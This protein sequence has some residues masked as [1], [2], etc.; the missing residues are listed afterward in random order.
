[1]SL[2]PLPDAADRLAEALTEAREPVVDPRGDLGVDAPR[3]LAHATDMALDVGE[4]YVPLFLD[5]D[6]HEKRPLVGDALQD[7][8]D[9]GLLNG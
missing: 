9:E 6:E 1:V 4:P 5:G 3:L 2:H 8:A 7:H